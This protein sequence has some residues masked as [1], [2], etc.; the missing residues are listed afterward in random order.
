MRQ[1]RSL[2]QEK[3]LEEL[4]RK[5]RPLKSQKG[6][7]RRIRYRQEIWDEILSL[8]EAGVPREVLLE[9][10]GVSTGTLSMRLGN[11]IASKVKL[12]E[13]LP[14]QC[15][16]SNPRPCEVVLNN[17]VLIRVPLDCLS[18]PILKLLKSC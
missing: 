18:E 14:E 2:L 15:S 13:V 4:A 11:G 9:V 5:C 17:G 7:G 6:P 8:L 10:S 12:I 3:R 16:R 1:S